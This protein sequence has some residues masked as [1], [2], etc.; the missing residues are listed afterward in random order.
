[1]KTKTETLASALA[2]ARVSGFAITDRDREVMRLLAIPLSV[3]PLL[4]GMQSANEIAR[5][6]R[7]EIEAALSPTP[8]S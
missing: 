4:S 2:H 1:M 6:L 7:L 8:L 5:A 3:A